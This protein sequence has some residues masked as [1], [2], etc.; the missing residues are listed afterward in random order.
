M[1]QLSLYLH[2]GSFSPESSSKTSLK[3]F[4]NNS[5][6]I[7]VR[8]FIDEIWDKLVIFPLSN[9]KLVHL[10]H[11]PLVGV[12]QTSRSVRVISR[13][14]FYFFWL[15]EYWA[16]AL[17]RCLSNTR[18]FTNMYLFRWDDSFWAALFTPWR[19]HWVFMSEFGI[20]NP[21]KSFFSLTHS[22]NK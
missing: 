9:P 22:N 21:I 4:S 5:K 10:A 1:S 17:E 14:S 12:F 19:D 20:I 11:L 3:S 7:E 13:L 15:A 18:R 16:C 2:N 8:L 6:V